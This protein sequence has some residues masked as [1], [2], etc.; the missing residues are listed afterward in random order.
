MNYYIVVWI[1]SCPLSKD[2]QSILLKYP[3]RQLTYH[4]LRRNIVLV[5]ALCEIIK[6][7]LFTC[8]AHLIWIRNFSHLP[9]PPSY[10]GRKTSKAKVSLWVSLCLLARKRMR[11]YH[12]LEGLSHSPL[13]I[14]PFQLQHDQEG[15]EHREAGHSSRPKDGY[16]QHLPPSKVC[17][18]CAGEQRWSSWIRL[19]DGPRPSAGKDSPME[20]KPPSPAC[21]LWY[22]QLF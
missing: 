7:I 14:C 19:G 10:D 18:C 5:L 11:Y 6:C 1:S 16:E 22:T 3:L 20:R 12:V 15:Q 9:P 13:D 8:K 2:E 4:T 17:G 21:F